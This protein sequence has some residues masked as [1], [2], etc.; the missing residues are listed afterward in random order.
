MIDYSAVLKVMLEAALAKIMLLPAERIQQFSIKLV[1][2]RE[3]EQSRGFPTQEILNPVN[4][5]L[6][7]IEQA[8]R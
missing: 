5:L 7:E 4:D 1:E 6:L 3:I 8:M 2:V